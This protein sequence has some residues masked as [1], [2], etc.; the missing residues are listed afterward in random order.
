[1]HCTCWSTLLMPTLTKQNHLLH[2]WQSHQSIIKSRFPS[3]S[4]SSPSWS[5]SF[6]PHIEH[7]VFSLTPLSSILNFS[8]LSHFLHGKFFLESL[9]S[10]NCLAWNLS[11]QLH[12]NG[13]WSLH[14]LFKDGFALGFFKP[15]IAS[16]HKLLCISSIR[17]GASLA[18]FVTVIFFLVIISD[19]N[20]FTASGSVKI[21]PFRFWTFSCCVAKCLNGTL[22]W[23]GFQDFF[24]GSFNCCTSTR[25][26][27]LIRISNSTFCY[28]LIHF[29]SLQDLFLWNRLFIE[30][31]N[32][33]FS[34]SRSGM[35]T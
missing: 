33:W 7:M 10:E 17:S 16:F 3:N 12:V 31:A 4:S 25:S 21:S 8:C 23:L 9:T 5:G 30:W 20:L 13:F 35:F 24:D 2:F 27:C 1:M 15:L 34:K 29:S 14:K 18:F 28:W 26:W 19:F 11:T 22:R 32:T 6:L